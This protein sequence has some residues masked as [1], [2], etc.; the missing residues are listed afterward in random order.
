[1]NPRGG[2][3]SNKTSIPVVNHDQL[4]VKFFLEAQHNT[5]SLSFLRNLII[6]YSTVQEKN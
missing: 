2:Q 3:N 6:K 5:E 4:G 1:M